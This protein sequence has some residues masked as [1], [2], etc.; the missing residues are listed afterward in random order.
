MTATETAK[1]GVIEENVFLPY[2]V[3]RVSI[4]NARPHPTQLVESAAMSEVSPPRP[5]YTPRLP[6]ESISPKEGNESKGLSLPQIEAIVYAGMAH[7][8]ILPDGKRKAYM[9]G[10]G[11]GVGKGRAIAGIIF[12]NWQRGRKKAVWVS[13]KWNLLN[14]AKR[15]WRD[16]VFGDPK[17]FIDGKS[18]RKN[19]SIIQ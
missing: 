8:K 10:D 7:E 17:V 14:S 6:E 1:T 18:I 4:E 13:E 11:P 15:D 9:I 12:D 3:S 5:T 2:V 16:A 19:R